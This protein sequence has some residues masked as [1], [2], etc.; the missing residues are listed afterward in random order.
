MY[1]SLLCIDSYLHAGAEIVDVLLLR[2]ELSSS[3]SQVLVSIQAALSA[4]LLLQVPY[5]IVIFS[6]KPRQIGLKGRYNYRLVITDENSEY[7][8]DNDFTISFGLIIIA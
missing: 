6:G 1:D 5:K 8:S 7:E 3:L 4:W 2:R